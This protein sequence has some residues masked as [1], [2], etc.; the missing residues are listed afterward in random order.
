MTQTKVARKQRLT[1]ALRSFSDVQR[2][3]F[4]G[5]G[6]EAGYLQSLLLNL[7]NDLPA[8]KVA[9]LIATLEQ[10]TVRIALEK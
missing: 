9:E 7:S 4:T 1:N 10:A 6:Y 2:K 8:H 3:V 5:Y